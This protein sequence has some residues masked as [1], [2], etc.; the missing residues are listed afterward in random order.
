MV[1]T[2]NP[3]T[4]KL[5]E[6]W[7]PVMALARNSFNDDTTNQPDQAG[8]RLI[9]A[10]DQAAARAHE[11]GFDTKEV[12]LSLFAV[13]S[14]IDE[15]AMTTAWS[16]AHAWRLAPLQRRY[17]STTH[18]GVQF[19]ERLDALDDEATSVREVYAM[20]L[21]AGF[22][23]H[24]GHGREGELTIYRRRLLERVLAEHGMSAASAAHPLFPG[25]TPTEYSK[26][27]YSRRT[28]PLWAWVLVV[29]GPLLILVLLY[30]ILNTSLSIQISSLFGGQS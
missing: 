3:T 23:G 15:L 10:L 7:L 26:Q 16:G 25:A 6:V 14:W 5:A 18:A 4:P 17:F 24:F 2:S 27:R 11:Y 21:I 19:F 13:V 30:V 29:G 1:N 22:H 8:P 28:R 12:E 20:V 9:T